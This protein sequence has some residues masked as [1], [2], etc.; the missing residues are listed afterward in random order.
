MWTIRIALNIFLWTF[1]WLPLLATKDHDHDTLTEKLIF[2]GKGFLEMG[3]LLLRISILL[4]LLINNCQIVF[5]EVCTIFFFLPTVEYENTHFFKYLSIHLP[6][7]NLHFLLPVKSN[8]FPFLYISHFQISSLFSFIVLHV[9]G[10]LFSQSFI[11]LICKKSLKLCYLHL[12]QVNFFI[13]IH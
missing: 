3:V 1:K 12:L 4:R 9:Y 8:I 2:F 7:F 10:H 11:L 13:G 5:K 6:H